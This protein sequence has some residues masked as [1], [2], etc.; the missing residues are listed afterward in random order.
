MAKGYFDSLSTE[1]YNNIRTLINRMNALGITNKYAQ[2]G[3][4]AVISKESAFK[5]AYESGYSKTSND[6]IR[7]IFAS[8]RAMKDDALNKLKSSDKDF[9]NF[10]YGGRFGNVA[11]TDDGYKYR[12]GGFNQ[13]TFKANYLQASKDSGVDLLKNPEMIN[14][15]RTAS[16]AVIGYFKRRFTIGKRNINGYS[17]LNTAVNDIY[18]ANAGKL[19]QTISVSEPTGGFAKALSRA[20]GFY[21]FIK[22]YSGDSGTAN[23]LKIKAN[24]V[25][26]IK[27]NKRT[28][29]VIF[30]LILLVIVFFIVKK[31][32]K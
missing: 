27:K 10:V 1:Q 28:Y 8:T 3:V 22:Q 4:L 32:T 31:T 30:L 17:D 6:R 2:A 18:A 5:P 12:G 19:G 21:E 9:F 23:F 26:H 16:D 20:S 13:I 14:D 11:G 7:S 15:V 25:Q 29:G 24:F